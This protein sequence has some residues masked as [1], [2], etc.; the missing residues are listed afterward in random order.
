[1]K[2]IKNIF[3]TIIPIFVSVFMCTIGLAC[4][5]VNNKQDPNL[6]LLSEY[7]K[8]LFVGQGG[9]YLATF[10]SGQREK[11]FI[12]NGERTELVDFGVLTVKF[13]YNFG[14]TLPKFELKVN[15]K[16][17][18]GELEKNPYDG[19]YVFDIET[20][21][22][23]SDLLSLYLVDIDENLN[24]ACWSKNWNIS[25]KTALEIFLNKHKTHVDNC[26]EQGKFNGEIFIKIVSNDK[27]LSN[28]CWYILLVCSN[29]EVH[30]SLI[31]V[32]SG[33]IVQN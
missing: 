2:K 22:E 33:E 28:V 14:E 24:L 19:T 31:D 9:N 23:D 3:K 11:D 20:Q 7:R 15:D 26:Y 17:F 12:M 6:S 32:N 29:G 16:I 5:H 21:V 30:A 4:T 1:M 10:T 18:S 8:N 25:Y 27:Q 13:N